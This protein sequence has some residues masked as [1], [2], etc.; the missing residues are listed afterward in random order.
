VSKR[1]DE[2]ARRKQIL[3]EQAAHQ[4]AELSG[5]CGRI[6]S[7]FELG[8]TLIGLSRALKTHPLI[9]AAASSFIVSGYASRLV[10]ST[11]ELLKLWKLII[12]VWA[13]WRSRRKIS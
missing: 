11:A 4:R 12:P 1:L 8:N 13:W 3:I 5:I 2:I 7:P 6:R 9:A 10:K